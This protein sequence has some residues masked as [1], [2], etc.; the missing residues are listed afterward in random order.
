MEAPRPQRPLLVAAAAAFAGSALGATG[1]L[2]PASGRAVALVACA[3]LAAV[4]GNACASRAALVAL[5]AAATSLRAGSL[6]GAPSSPERT[7][8]GT[9]RPIGSGGER[10]LGTVA[11]GAQTLA[12]VR[13][14]LDAGE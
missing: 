10:D 14:T 12:L 2:Q 11:S 3:W 5:L 7:T 9:W 6:E 4:R 8:V 1:A 13:G